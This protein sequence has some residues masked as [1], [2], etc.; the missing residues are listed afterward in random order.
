[1]WEGSACRAVWGFSGI[2]GEE[3]NLPFLWG[4]GAD[5]GLFLMAPLPEFFT[6]FSV[7]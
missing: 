7:A 1:M 4:L 5:R 6:A 2:L 3:E